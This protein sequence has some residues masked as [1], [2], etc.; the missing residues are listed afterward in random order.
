VQRKCAA[1]EIA[2]DTALIR[3]LVGAQFPDWAHLPV[4]PVAESGW[5]NR[6]F[7]LGS[8]MLVRMP[9]AEHYSTQVHKEQ[10]WLPYLAPHL[11]LPIPT[12]LALGKPNADFAM[13]WSI[14]RWLEGETAS[15]QRVDDLPAFA[16]QIAMF[17]N[18]LRNIDT[19]G[20]P[21]P[22]AHNFHRG[23][24]LIVYDEEAQSAVATLGRAIDGSAVLHA[25][26]AA[27][28]S[29]WRKLPVWVHGD[30]APGNLL[31]RN[32]VL[33]AVID[34]GSCAVGDPACD[35]AIAWTFFDRPSRRSFRARLE[36]DNDTWLRAAGWALWK[37][38]IVLARAQHADPEIGRVSRRTID[39][40]IADVS[41]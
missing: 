41:L 36:A 17:L 37:A 26:E 2:V 32:G 13:P 14:Y 24:D 5:D 6:T 4:Q 28:G 22:G 27:L 25:W 9:S 31:V 10:R 21:E 30:V 38:V 39:A 40:V 20:A 34:F 33:S 8:E 19:N 18:T 35:L 23:G 7:R 3:Q 11:P 16:V 29:R 15:H 1:D 12:P